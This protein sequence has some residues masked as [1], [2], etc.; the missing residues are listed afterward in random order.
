MGHSLA[1]I[2]VSS[3]AA[4]ASASE[5][6]GMVAILKHLMIRCP[7]QLGHRDEMKAL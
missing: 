7:A 6:R 2:R 5:S 4:V 3:C 1:A